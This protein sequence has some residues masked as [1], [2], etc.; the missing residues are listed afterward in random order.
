MCALGLA[1]VLRGHGLAAVPIREAAPLS[2]CSLA[3][4]EPPGRCRGTHEHQQVF[5]TPVGCK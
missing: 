2:D 5:M 3:S 1:Q 4:P